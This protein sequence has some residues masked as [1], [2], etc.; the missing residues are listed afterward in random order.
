MNYLDIGRRNEVYGDGKH[1]DSAAIQKCLDEMRDG[2]T[3]HFPSGVY[4]LSSTL[5]FYSNQHLDFEDGATLLRSAESETVT[6]YLLA[7]YSDSAMGGYEGTHDVKI[8]GCTFDGNSELTEK[9]TLLNTVHCRNIKIDG[10]T[11]INCSE[12][13][14]I[15]L[16]SSE[17]VLVTNCIFDGPSYTAMREDLT[18]ELIQLDAPRTWTYGPVYDYTGKLIEFLPDETPCKNIRIEHNIFRCDGFTAIGH[19]GDDAHTGIKI[20]GNSFIGSSGKNGKSRG[21]ITFLELVSGVEIINNAFFSVPE[22]ETLHY[23]IVIK[24]PEKTAC[25]AENNKFIGYFDEYFI[26]GITYENNTVKDWEESDKN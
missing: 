6:R 10:C 5:I 22:K 12:W 1:D 7:S 3:I 26:G 11:F 21:Y 15:E 14:C 13:H 18:S 9:T 2:G 23:G 20:D 25:I 8:T 17:N 4:L 19:H 24:N 16:N